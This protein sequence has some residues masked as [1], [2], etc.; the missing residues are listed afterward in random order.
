MHFFM[1]AS[2]NIPSPAAIAQQIQQSFAA[3]QNGRLQESLQSFESLVQRQASDSACWI[4]LALTCLQLSHWERADQA[5]EEV[6]RKEPRHLHALILKG[7]LLHQQTQFRTALTYY[8][9]ALRFAANNA[10][11][12]PALHSELQRAQAQCARYQEQFETQLR[13]QLAVKD[14][15]AGETSERFNESLDLLTGKKSIYLQQ[16]KIYYFPGLPQIQF[17]DNKVFPWISKLEAAFREIRAELLTLMTERA[18]FEP[19]VKDMPNRPKNVGGPMQNNPDWGAFHLISHGKV[20]AENAARCPRTMQALEGLPLTHMKNRSPSAM[21]SLLRPGTRIPPHHG[22]VNTRLICHL[23]LIV[24][25][26]CGLRVGNDRREVVEG[27]AW[28][29]DDSIEHEA[30]NLSD[31]VRVILL[32][33]IWR[34]ELSPHERAQVSAMFEAIEDHQ[35]GVGEWSI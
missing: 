5:L 29:F 18:E 34:P 12:P 22:L 16:P 25:P 33:E 21:F 2:T 23:P 6:L 31:Q 17:Y 32:F 4:G 35:G 13:Q 30:W 15:A 3:L 8:Q 19:Y 7:D 26:Q 11:L 14:L 9:A 10:Q 27:K 28:V 20:Q 1:P 24:P